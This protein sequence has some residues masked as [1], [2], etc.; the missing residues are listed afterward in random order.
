MSQAQ[1]GGAIGKKLKEK[2]TQTLNDALG[3]KSQNQTKEAESNSGKGDT[4]EE[5]TPEKVMAMV[6]TMPTPQQLAEYL[7]ESHRA[8][9]RTLKMLANPTT[10][11]MAQLAVA[12]VSGYASMASQS[13][14]GGYVDF[15]EQLLKEFGITKEQYDAMSE[16]Q[17][18]E[19]ALKYAGE[20]Q[21][22]YYKTL[23]RLGKDE[24][25]NRLIEQYNNIEARIDK[26]Y[27]DADSI[28]NAMWQSKYGSK[29]NPSED[30]MCTYYQ[31]ATTS[32]CQTVVNVMRIR[33]SEQL[34]LAKQIDSYVQKL[35]LRYPNEVYSGLYSQS[36]IC[37][38]SYVADAARV[39]SLP[40]PR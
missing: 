14:Y 23:E 20:M 16:D 18:Q 26:M 1:I 13:A 36:S 3:N 17:Q 33:K 35:A 22:R 21:D 6:P 8:N 2:A 39:T 9:P 4:E 27:S 12:G 10:N 31:Q 40:D 24:E 5:L 7:C 30:D 29:A 19:L 32:Y 38:A 34:V 28:C 11:Y 15:D 25:Y 37:A